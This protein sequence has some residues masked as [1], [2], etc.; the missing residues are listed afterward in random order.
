[1]YTPNAI[2]LTRLLLNGHQMGKNHLFKYSHQVSK[3]DLFIDE[4]ERVMCLSRGS[5]TAAK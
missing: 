2:N 3:Y 1:M 4:F 5:V